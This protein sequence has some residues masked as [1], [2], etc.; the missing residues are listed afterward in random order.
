MKN[1][2]AHIIVPKRILTL[3]IIIFIVFFATLSFAR[4][5]NFHSRRLDLGNMDQTVWNVL[6]GNGFTL[7]DPMGTSQ[8]SRL[9]VHADFLL[10]ALAP[11]Y[12]LWS[13]PKMLL[14]VQV[15]IA[16]LGAI[17]V[18]WLAYELLKSKKYALLFAVAYLL[19]PP[20]GR[21]M[22]HDFHSVA[23]T[24]TF[25]LY[26]YWYM[27]KKNFLLF[28]LFATLAALGKEEVWITVSMMG[29]YIAIWKKSPVVGLSMAAV[30]GAI[31]YI[32]FWIA[33][34]AVTPA[35]Q[36]FALIY[37]SEY[38]NTLNEVL[39]NLITHPQLAISTM[40]RIDRLLYYIQLLFP[41]GLLSI[42]SPLP[43]LFSLESIVINSLS[44]NTLMRQI[45]Y[46][47]TDII[48]PFVMISAIY[49]FSFLLRIIKQKKIQFLKT[50]VPVFFISYLCMCIGISLY[51]W[52]EFPVG[53]SQWFWFFISPV[54]ERQIMTKIADSIDSSYSVSATNNIGAHFSQRQILYNFPVK[55]DSA[56][57]TVVYLGDTYAWPSGSDQQIAVRN[58]LK[59]PNYTLIAQEGNFFAFKKI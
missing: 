34:P 20:L 49:G 33:I 29:I 39:K 10:I 22:L 56:D 48:T 57:Y 47:Y 40:L 32:L 35:K 27:E 55:G 45:D 25:L 12:A 18:Y 43:L 16:G 1:I 53:K 58:L 2:L 5:D 59:N 31:F 14:L 8:Q 23:L 38:G 41:L 36:H 6:H 30:A 4:H 37:L 19:Y 21:N 46:Q 50:N 9:A 17:P 28:T 3:Q 52:G 24:T 44:N 11:L 26:A 54:P 7:T 51:L 13:N 42:L 15:I